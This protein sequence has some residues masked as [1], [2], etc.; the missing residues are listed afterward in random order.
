MKMI[1]PWQQKGWLFVVIVFFF[2]GCSSPY[3]AVAEDL[4]ASL[5]AM[6]DLDYDRAREHLDQL[7]YNG[8]QVPEIYH[9]RGLLALEQGDY[10]SALGYLDQAYEDLENF[11]N[12]TMAYEMLVNRGTIYQGTQAYAKALAMYNQAM[13]YQ[14][15]AADLLN[16]KGLVLRDLGQLD[17][18]IEAYNQAL[19]LDPSYAYAYANRGEIFMLDQA[20]DLALADANTALNIDPSVP[21][22]MDLKASIYKGMGELNQALEVYNQGLQTW[23]GYGLFYLKRGELYLSMGRY[24]DALVDFGLGKEFDEASALKGQGYG[25]MGIADYPGA[26]DAFVS[27]LNLTG[28]TEVPVLY[29]IGRAHY[30]LEN[31]EE[32]L[33]VVET[34]LEIDPTM[35]AAI[36]LKEKAMTLQDLP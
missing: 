29:E 34:L 27:Y 24:S 14:P 1:K 26:I 23:S 16:A 31:K 19:T 22:F 32:V 12:D 2:G 28:K 21:Q 36:E 30:A 35:E 15:E 9:L 25:Y 3:D 5:D 33:Q 13:E 10:E 4:Q 8:D 20:Y 17:Q 18:A 6:A 11:K 7:E